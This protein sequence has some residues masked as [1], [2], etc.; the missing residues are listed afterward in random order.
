MYIVPESNFKNELLAN[1]ILTFHCVIILFILVAP[2]S[3]VPALLIL[4]IT[5]AICL[6]LHWAS[7]QNMCSL[8]ILEAQLRGNH[9]TDT[10]T[11]RFIGP[12]YDITSEE[13][14]VYVYIITIVLMIIS[15]YNLYYS[16]KFIDAFQCFN[17]ISFDNTTYYDKIEMT[18]NCFKT[19]F[20]L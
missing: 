18:F 12:L 6:I 19:L 4:H 2:F 11:H 7:N 14:A 9:Y 1:L 5:F 20:I 10:F 15:M 13:W 17:L 8:T 3:N 16:P